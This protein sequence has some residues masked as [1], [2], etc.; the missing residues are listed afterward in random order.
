MDLAWELARSGDCMSL[1]VLFS[2]SSNPSASIAAWTSHVQS[3][4]DTCQ[5]RCI[6]ANGDFVPQGDIGGAANSPGEMRPSHDK[7]LICTYGLAANQGPTRYERVRTLHRLPVE[8]GRVQDS[9]SLFH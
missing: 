5:N 2:S 6:A 9:L 8:L 4:S 1:A 3:S 7:R